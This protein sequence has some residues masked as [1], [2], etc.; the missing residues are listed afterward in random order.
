M[1]FLTVARFAKSL[2][3]LKA[4]IPPMLEREPY[5]NLPAAYHKFY[6][7]W[8]F[9]EPSPV[10]YRPEEGRY[11]DRVINLPIPT[12]WTPELDNMLLGGEAIIK[13]YMQ[14]K[15]NKRRVPRWWIPDIF[16]TVVYS[17]ILDKYMS[18]IAT[19][20][21]IEL[22]HH[23]QG[24]D[25]YILKSPACDLRS[26]LAIKI[27]RQILL[28]LAK[29]D[30]YPEDPAKKAAIL[31]KYKDYTVPLDEAEWYGLTMR[32][33]MIK[34]HLSNNQEEPVPLKNQYRMELIEYL[35]EQRDNPDAH[36]SSDEGSWLKQ[37]KTKV[38]FT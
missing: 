30:F 26:N 6:A 36:K 27:K 7:E 8:K 5:K 24:F 37:L 20:K 25:N 18:V 17:E 35:K 23:H 33:A 29:Q 9:N 12:I 16:K 28:A 2:Q 13:G 4:R 21:L 3:L 15:E 10:N 32:E 34:N 38:S 19:R 14:K 31:E 22:V 11:R 1:V